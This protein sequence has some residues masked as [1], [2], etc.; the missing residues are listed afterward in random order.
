MGSAE[1]NVIDVYEMRFDKF[2]SL[3]IGSPADHT[4]PAVV[5]AVRRWNE[6]AIEGDEALEM[7]WEDQANKEW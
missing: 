1:G 6:Y 3:V 5:R 2:P 7:V 4:N